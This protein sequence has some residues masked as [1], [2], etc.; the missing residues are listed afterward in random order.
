MSDY[1]PSARTTVLVLMSFFAIALPAIW[2]TGMGY[3]W[4][5]EHGIKFDTATKPE[6]FVDRIVVLLAVLPMIPLLV[7]AIFVS[8]IPW[9]FVMSRVLSWPDIQHFTKQKGPRLPFLSALLDRLWLRMIESRRP[10]S[11]LGGASQ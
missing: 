5:V 10:A 1:K 6:G 9:M 7:L 3:M 8:G 4:L 2:F 11:P